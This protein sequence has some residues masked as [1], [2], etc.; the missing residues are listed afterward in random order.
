MTLTLQMVK[1]F[2]KQDLT[3]H[4]STSDES[5][6]DPDLDNYSPKLLKEK[7]WKVISESER[8]IAVGKW[9]QWIFKGGTALVYGFFVRSKEKGT[10]IY[11]EK[12]HDGPY[13]IARNGDKLRIRPKIEIE[14]L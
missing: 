8:T 7:D 9:V 6:I 2:I 4:L 12:F 14:K 11:K 10:L 1:E 3:V 5:A 13:R